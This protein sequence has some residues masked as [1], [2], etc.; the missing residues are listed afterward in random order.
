MGLK[1]KIA[2]EGRTFRS[3]L[4]L[5][6]SEAARPSTAGPRTNGKTMVRRMWV[7]IAAMTIALTL[8]LA[9]HYVEADLPVGYETIAI[10][11]ISFICGQAI[12]RDL[13]GSGFVFK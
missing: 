2:G 13:K 11:A 6:G 1:D 4:G 10:M 9:Y 3:S 8:P 5:E 12:F 7:G